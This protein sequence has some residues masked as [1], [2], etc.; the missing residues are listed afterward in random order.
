S[1][2][3]GDGPAQHSEQTVGPY[4]LADFFLYQL[5][6]FGHRPSK[7]AYLAACAWSDRERGR[8]PDLI[9]AAA[10]RQYTPAEIRHWLEVFLVRFFQTSQFKRSALPNAPKVGSGGSLSPRS[11]W[12]APSDAVAAAWLDELRKRV[13]ETTPDPIPQRTT[14]SVDSVGSEQ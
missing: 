2:H 4:E 9:P 13:G 11:D 5:R 12:R 7:V 10:R 1:D 3:D 14:S 6:R 8:W